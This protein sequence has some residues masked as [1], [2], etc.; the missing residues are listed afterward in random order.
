MCGDC[1]GGN[2]RDA[3]T[4]VKGAVAETKKYDGTAVGD[5]RDDLGPEKPIGESNE[6][7]VYTKKNPNPGFEE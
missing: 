3:V 1:S 4:K 5:K 7:G 6:S 2:L